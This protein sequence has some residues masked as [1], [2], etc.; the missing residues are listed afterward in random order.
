MY[1]DADY[2]PDHTSVRAS[3]DAVHNSHGIK[4]LD[5][6]KSTNLRILNGRI[7]NSCKHTFYAHNGSSVIDYLLTRECN[8]SLLSNFTVG[9]FNQWS[10]HAPLHFALYCNNFS[11]NHETYTDVKYKW[12]SS[13][14]EQFRSGI[15]TKLPAFNDIVENID[16]LDRVSINDA[17]DLFTT[18]IR[19]VADPLFSKNCNYS[20]KPSFE[21]ESCMKSADWFDNDWVHARH[22]YQE[23]LSNF[24][25]NKIDVNRSTLCS[26]KKYYKDLIRK[27]KKCAFRIKMKE[28]ENL[29]RSKPKEFWKFFK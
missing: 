29:R 8:F 1:D 2:V 20:N 12:N 27:K 15:I 9:D 18:T 13:L 6:C 19:S 23:T 25:K 10:D 17:L 14:R 16:C 5:M 4:L 3:V 26:R 28:I 21:T 24:N 11:P 7:G 22:L